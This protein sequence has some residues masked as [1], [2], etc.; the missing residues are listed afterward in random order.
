M[1]TLK[2]I[3]KN[4]T[5]VVETNVPEITHSNC[6]CN[7]LMSV[8]LTGE[9]WILFILISVLAIILIVI[10]NIFVLWESQ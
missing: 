5:I 3:S 10:F 2:Q 7:K 9:F 8:V 6:V 4:T 1:S